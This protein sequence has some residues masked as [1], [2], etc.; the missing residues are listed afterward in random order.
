MLPKSQTPSSPHRTMLSFLEDW[1]T[2]LKASSL[3]PKKKLA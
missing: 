1:P 2:N 3:Q